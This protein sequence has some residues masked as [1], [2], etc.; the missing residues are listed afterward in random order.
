M[1]HSV[2]AKKRI[3][4][5]ERARVRNVDRRSAMKTEIKRFRR[6]LE[7]GDLALAEK[8]L[9]RCAGLLDRAAKTGAIHRRLAD[10]SKSRLALALGKAKAA[11]K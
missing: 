8:S 7:V 2:S 3:R 1:A 6:A 11:K 5:N 9:P 4:Q 10:R